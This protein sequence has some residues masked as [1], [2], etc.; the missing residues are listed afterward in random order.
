MI[1][2]IYGHNTLIRLFEIASDHKTQPTSLIYI[3]LEKR[4]VFTSESSGS[5]L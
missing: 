3:L 4:L 2:Y 5:I 1:L